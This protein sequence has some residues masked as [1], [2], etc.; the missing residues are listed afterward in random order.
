MYDCL[1]D[2][3]HIILSDV[4]IPSLNSDLSLCIINMIQNNY[5]IFPN[6][7][8]KSIIERVTPR[9]LFT[10]GMPSSE[11]IIPYTRDREKKI[12]SE[13]HIVPHLASQYNQL[14]TTIALR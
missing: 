8:S 4:F 6:I 11:V 7:L 13:S 14:S 5:T 1:V 2:I 12:S 3:Y 10:R 9:L